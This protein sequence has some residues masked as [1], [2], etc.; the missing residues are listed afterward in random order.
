LAAKIEEFSRLSASSI[1]QILCTEYPVGAGI[2][3]H[4]DKRHFENVFGLSLGSACT[5]RLRRK[6]GEAW[7]RFALNIESRSLYT[8]RGEARHVWEH[9]ISPMDA[10]R[11]S[12]TFR[13]MKDA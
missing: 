5:L 4:R 9:S 8:M 1:S 13:T 6:V 12:I 7:E 2:G 10:V 3:W 11:Y